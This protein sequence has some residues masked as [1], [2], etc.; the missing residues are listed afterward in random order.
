MFER[1][2][3][4]ESTREKY[5]GMFTTGSHWGMNNTVY[6]SCLCP[7][8]SAQVSD[9]LGKSIG[10]WSE[11]GFFGQQRQHFLRVQPKST[12]VELAQNADVEMTIEPCWWSSSSSSSP[13]FHT[14]SNATTTPSYSSRTRLTF[15]I[16]SVP[17]E[18]CRMNVFGMIWSSCNESRMEGSRNE[19]R[20]LVSWRDQCFLVADSN[21]CP[22]SI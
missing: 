14:E 16:C 1:E 9:F 22:W 17:I 19:L 18:E 4:R 6:R 8:D 13:A 10:C 7:M 21:W 20:N 3:T 12:Y 15:G 5:K 2:S 11:Q